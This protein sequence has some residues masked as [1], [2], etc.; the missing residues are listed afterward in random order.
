[1]QNLK[2]FAFAILGAGALAFN[3]VNTTGCEASAEATGGA[4]GE[5]GAAGS[6]TAG[7]GGSAAGTAGAAGEAG[8]AG[9]AAGSGGSGG[10]GTSASATSL[11]AALGTGDA[12]S[13]CLGKLSGKNVSDT[14]CTT[15]LAKC[16]ADVVSADNPNSCADFIAT[17][18]TARTND[19]TK[20]PNCWVESA[21]TAASNEAGQELLLCA[22]K[23]D[24]D[25]GCATACGG[26][27]A[28]FSPGFT[29]E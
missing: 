18:A 13:T 22:A 26:D 16:D 6:T 14:D 20:S 24:A 15:A 23:A 29:C 1:M 21:G 8:A 11:A 25:G 9:A 17:L 28:K 10:S 27:P 12:C 4:A 5:A 2:L 7:S 19:P 3:T